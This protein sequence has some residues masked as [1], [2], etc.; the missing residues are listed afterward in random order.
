MRYR[1]LGS[2]AAL[3]LLVALAGARLAGQTPKANTTTTK[4]Y[5]VPHTAD[6]QA[7]LQG[8]WSFAT[9]TPLQRPSELAGKQTFTDEEAAQFEK[10]ELARRDEDRRDNAVTGTTN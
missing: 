10:G 7:D 8:V 3:A 4:S 2:I 5:T 9:L 1:L 6:G